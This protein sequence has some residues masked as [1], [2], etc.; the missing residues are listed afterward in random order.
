MFYSSE[1]K[2]ILA[3]RRQGI[4]QTHTTQHT[5]QEIY[6]KDTKTVAASDWMRS[7][8][9]LSRRQAYIGFLVG[10]VFQNEEFQ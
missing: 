9:E 8:R 5:S 2:A 4:P 6:R 10:R 1:E 3:V 7:S